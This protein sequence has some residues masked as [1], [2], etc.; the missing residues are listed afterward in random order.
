MTRME[1]VVVPDTE[2]PDTD[3]GLVVLRQQEGGECAEWLK[4]AIFPVIHVALSVRAWLQIPD[5]G[6]CGQ[7]YWVAAGTPTQFPPGTVIQ[8]PFGTVSQNDIARN[9]ANFV[10]GSFPNQPVWC[11]EN[12]FL[13]YCAAYFPHG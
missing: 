13:M 4:D 9:I 3:R 7:A 1:P 5:L 10:D 11:I 6:A 12:D 2:G 8:Y